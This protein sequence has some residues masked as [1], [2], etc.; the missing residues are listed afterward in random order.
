MIW[1]TWRQFRIQAIAGAVLLVLLVAAVL[2]SWREVADLASSTG[3]TGCSGAACVEAAKTFRFEVSGGLPS[4]VYNAATAALFL[5]PALIGVFWGAP[6]V[7]RELESGT[8]RMI[9][10]QSVGRGRWL[11]VKLAFGASAVV[12]G[13][14]LLSLLLTWWAG[15]IDAAGGDRLTPLVFPGRGVVPIAYAAAGFVIGVTLGLVLRRTV[16]AM[17][18]TLLVVIGLQ[19]AAP[20]VFRPLLAGVTV[21]VA[22]LDPTKDLDGIGMNP[23]TGVMHLQADPK[24]PG[25]WILSSSVLGADG[26][27]FTG[28]ADLTK[29]GPKGS[30]ENCT[31]WL[32]TQNLSVRIRYV[33]AGKFW[34]VQWRE[35]ALLAGL[36]LVLSALSMWWIRRKLV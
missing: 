34:T 19:V 26:K 8:Y 32:R 12:L 13:V 35:F 33:P 21:S 20:L 10:S 27:P 36:T 11:L 1:L 28:P 30:F 29:C 23:D 24:I 15:R 17:A 3:Y 4:A 14:G 22:A 7:A 9:F 25:A 6:T 2:I 5:A 18:V 16:V 31:D